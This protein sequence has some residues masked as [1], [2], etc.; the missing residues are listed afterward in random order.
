MSDTGKHSFPHKK[1]QV[2]NIGKLHSSESAWTWQQRNCVPL[3]S[4]VGQA[5][6][7]SGS[8]DDIQFCRKHNQL[9][10]GRVR[11]RILDF[12]QTSSHSSKHHPHLV[13]VCCASNPNDC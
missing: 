7:R 9:P 11:E 6:V 4:S 3:Q 10:E 5:M 12:A 1:P 8:E 2:S 13:G